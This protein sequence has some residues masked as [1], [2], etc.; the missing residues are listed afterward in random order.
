L[1]CFVDPGSASIVMMHASNPNPTLGVAAAS[2][3]SLAARE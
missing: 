2:H 1:K 3:D